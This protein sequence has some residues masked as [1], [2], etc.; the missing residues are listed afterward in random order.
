MNIFG[1]FYFR[2]FLIQSNR[3]K[4]EKGKA[5]FYYR[6]YDLVRC[7]VVETLEWVGTYGQ[8]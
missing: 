6:F 2:Y 3:S 7:D 1:D 5:Q 8:T 4:S